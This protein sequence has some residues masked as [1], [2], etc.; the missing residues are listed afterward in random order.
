[1]KVSNWSIRTK[2][3]IGAGV[4]FATSI[5]GIVLAGTSMMY[6]TAGNEAEARARA[7]LAIRVS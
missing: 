4:M 5:C 6:G 7:L 2:L 1:M 3:V